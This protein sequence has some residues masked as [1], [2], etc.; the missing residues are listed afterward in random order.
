MFV[1]VARLD[2]IL[3]T[4]SYV[5]KMYDK[6]NF[7]LFFEYITSK[8]RIMIRNICHETRYPYKFQISVISSLLPPANG[9]VKII[10]QLCLSVILSV[11]LFIG[12]PPCHL[13]MD[14]FKHVLLGPPQ[15]HRP[16]PSPSAGVPWTCSNSFIM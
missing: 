8:M 16:P 13:Y 2:I 9:V 15:F 11:G 7:L 3:V 5:L 4:T 10:F 14:L 1:Q 6:R 12:G